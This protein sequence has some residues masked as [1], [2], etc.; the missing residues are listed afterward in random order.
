MMTKKTLN[1]YILGCI[2]S[3]ALL[4]SPYCFAEPTYHF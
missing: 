1:T 4:Y 2:L 3:G